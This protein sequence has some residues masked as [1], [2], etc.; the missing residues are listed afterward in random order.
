ADGLEFGQQL[1]G[2][3]DPTAH[4]HNQMLVCL[5]L[6]HLYV[7]KGD[8][9]QA[10]RTNERGLLICQTHGLTVYAGWF[11]SV[12]GY[13][14]AVAGP[15]PSEAVP[16]VADAVTQLTRI[17]FRMWLPSAMAHLAEAQ[18]LAGRRDDASEVATRALQLARQQKARGDE[19]WVLRLIGEIA[20]NPAV[21]NVEEAR[22]NYTQ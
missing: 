11:L 6:G 5:G 16:R 3:V 8:F 13:G 14:D 12:L 18:L 9:D 20:S 15:L 19:A 22:S 2:R 1:A 21:R 7:L 10:R 4:A 17:R